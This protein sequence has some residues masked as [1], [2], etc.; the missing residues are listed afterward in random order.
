M[1]Y[2]GGYRGWRYSP[3]DQINRSKRRTVEGEVGSPDGDHYTVETTPL[4]ADGV[5]YVSEPP[6]NVVA[7]DCRDR[8]PVLALPARAAA[9]DQRLLRSGE[10]AAWR[11]LGDRLFVGTVDAHLVALDARTGAVLWDVEVANYQHG[12]FGDRRAVDRQGQGD[13][14]HRGWRVRNS[15]LARCV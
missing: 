5:M 3:L 2:S 13:S 12:L 15:R 9:Q 4:V 8:P 6:S 7:L 10:I 14:R 11:L 1:T